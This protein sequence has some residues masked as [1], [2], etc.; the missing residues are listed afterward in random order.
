[1]DDT[2][3]IDVKINSGDLYDYMLRHAYHG[4]QGLLG[5]CVGAMAVIIFLGNHQWIYLIAGVVMLA[6]L[7]WSLFLKSKQQALN[8]PAFRETLH[9]E[10]NEEGISVSQGETTESM[11]WKDMYR[12]VS[13]SRSIIIYTTRVNACIF[14]RREL[15]EQEMDVIQFICTHMEPGKV[16]IRN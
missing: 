5:S 13:T 11:K 12:A 3:K 8:T 4:A 6:Y 10:F 16:K 7:P 15:K 1:M 9:Y 14:P 2:L